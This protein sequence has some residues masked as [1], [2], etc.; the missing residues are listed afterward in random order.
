MTIQPCWNALS[1]WRAA[2]EEFR[3]RRRTQRLPPPDP[4][5]A[6][7]SRLLTRWRSFAAA[8]TRRPWP[9]AWAVSGRRRSR[10]ATSRRA[11]LRVVRMQAGSSAHQPT[12]TANDAHPTPA[13]APGQALDQAPRD[14][15]REQRDH[16][17]SGSDGQPGP[18]R[19]P[20]PY[21]LTP[22]HDRQQHRS[23]RDGEEDHHGRRARE[24]PHAEKAGSISGLRLRRQ[25][26]TK[27]ASAAADR[28]G[29]P[30]SPAA[31]S[32]SRCL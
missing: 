21:V 28:S 4:P 6:A 26:A 31:P 10:S 2:I 19:R 17:W 7:C 23:E 29:R 32:P 27:P 1:S 3:A 8:A 11:C 13:T 24:G 15:E 9:S 18:Q 12:P 5:G 14:E 30:A 22:Q 25:W 20:A 16:Q